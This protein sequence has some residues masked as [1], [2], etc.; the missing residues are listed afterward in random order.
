M[1]V[2]SNPVNNPDLMNV[3]TVPPFGLNSLRRSLRQD[4]VIYIAHQPGKSIIDTLPFFIRQYTPT[5][6][7][8]LTWHIVRLPAQFN[9]AELERVMMTNADTLRKISFDFS[10]TSEPDHWEIAEIARQIKVTFITEEQLRNPTI[11]FLMGYLPNVITDT[12]PF[13]WDMHY[14]LADAYTSLQKG[15]VQFDTDYPCHADL[16][17]AVDLITGIGRRLNPDRDVQ[18][19]PTNVEGTR[20]RVI[21]STPKNWERLYGW[22][23][24]T[25]NGKISFSGARGLD[26]SGEYVCPYSAKVSQYTAFLNPTENPGYVQIVYGSLN[27]EDLCLDGVTMSSHVENAI[28]GQFP[29]LIQEGLKLLDGYVVVP[30][31]ADGS[32][33]LDRVTG[34]EKPG[35]DNDWQWVYNGAPVRIGTL[36]LN[37]DD[38]H[39]VK[40]LIPIE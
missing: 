14:A 13:G 6:E 10:P 15:L 29:R 18:V 5:D 8:D 35:K 25:E 17:M 16:G 30:T 40:Y 31:D 2:L 19:I 3:V 11:D 27:G 23:A 4:A 24:A 34:L 20:F 38:F 36:F 9:G 28:M 26:D 21:Y 7:Y 22:L 32:A 33:D 39:P 37:A 12:Q 1:T